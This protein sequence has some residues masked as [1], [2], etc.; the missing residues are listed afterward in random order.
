MSKNIN[1]A[2]LLCPSCRGENIKLNSDKV[3]CEVCGLEYKYENGKIIFTV[4]QKEDIGDSFDRVKYSVKKYNKIY[5][6]LI[7]VFSPVYVDKYSDKFIKKYCSGKDLIVLNLGSGNSNLSGNVSNVDLFNYPNVNLVCDIENLPLKDNSCDA[8]L[9]IAVLE[10]VKNPEKIVAEI[11]RVLKKGGLVF[12]FFPFI[13]GYH[14]SPFDFSR[15]T[16]EGI[17]YL[18]KDFESVEVKVAG[19]PASGFLWIFQEFLA[20]VLSFG[21]K[22]IHNLVLIFLMLIT[23]PVKYLDIVLRHFPA[24]ENISSGFYYI[25]KKN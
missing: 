12:S 5:D 25:G 7:R 24:A 2:I 21:I 8:I 19:G 23:F 15:R 20:L 3:I 11:Y 10:H 4:L 18:Y 22:K 6:F 1:P 17:K 13:Q 16:V 9:N 14:A